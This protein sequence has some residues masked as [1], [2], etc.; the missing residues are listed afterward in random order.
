MIYARIPA[1]Y[2]DFLRQEL[3]NEHD[4]FKYLTICF[5]QEGE[6]QILS[7]YFYGIDKGFFLDIG[8]Y[9]PI[10]YSN[11]YKFYLKG[12]RGINIDAM[13][14]SM[15]AFNK[16]RPED[17]NVETGVAENESDLP[18]YIFEQT[19]INTF[20][21]KFAVEMEDKGYVVSQ[22]KVTRTRT[23]KAILGE[24]LPPNQ[25]IDFLSLD[26]EGFELDVLNSNDWTRYRPR[27]IVVESLQLKSQ[28]VLDAYLHEVNYKLI[29]KTVN[30]VYYTDTTIDFL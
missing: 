12:W 18:Y 27:I 26:V 16:I 17:I 25:V 19:G 8:A 24:F 21:E 14:G 2:K 29:A 11:T 15:I 7:Q 6:D 20:S 30:N 23:M 5:S 10:K 1:S 3:L 9:H 4:Y 22:K 13:P 28:N